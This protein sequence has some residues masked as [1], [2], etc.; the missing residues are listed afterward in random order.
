MGGTLISKVRRSLVPIDSNSVLHES[1]QSRRAKG[2]HEIRLLLLRW[3]ARASSN[4]GSWPAGDSCFHQLSH[5]V[6]IPFFYFSDFNRVYGRW[7]AS[8]LLTLYSCVL[9]T[10]WS[11]TSSTFRPTYHGRFAPVIL[12]L[13]T[14]L[15][16]F[17]KLL[18]LTRSCVLYLSGKRK[19]DP[20]FYLTVVEHLGVEPC[21]CI[22]IDDRLGIFVSIIRYLK[23]PFSPDWGSVWYAG[24]PTSSVQLI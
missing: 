9:G 20:E 10:N 12:V 6:P 7:F 8:C 11:R 14:S 13:H 4:F 21:D 17:T 1:N 16:S 3:D 5:L 2:V 19:P 24:Q 18:L 15:A 23:K 22:F